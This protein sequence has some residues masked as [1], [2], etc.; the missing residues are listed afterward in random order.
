MCAAATPDRTVRSAPAGAHPLP[1]AGARRRTT[2][3]TVIVALLTPASS[4][5]WNSIT[6]LAKV[7]P[8]R[9]PQIHPQQHLGPVLRFRPAGARVY[10]HDRIARVVLAPEHLLNLARVDLR[11]QL[12]EPGSQIIRHTLALVGPLDEHVEV[13][14]PST[15]GFGKVVVFLQTAAALENL[16]CRGLIAPEGRSGSLLLEA[17]D[18]GLY[19]CSV[20]DNPA[21]PLPAWLGPD[22]VESV[23][24]ARSPPCPPFAGEMFLVS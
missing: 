19:T 20:K 8:F 13:L 10:R 9:P 1:A 6:S 18:L 7:R 17:R 3:F 24:R 4:P 14:G 22:I 23:H 2:P 11:L 21:G 15:Q 16:L 12:I 5:G